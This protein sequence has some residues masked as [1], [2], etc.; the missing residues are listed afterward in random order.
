[1]YKEIR[2]HW[3]W[4]GLLYLC[5]Q[6]SDGEWLLLTILSMPGTRACWALWW[7]TVLGMLCSLMGIYTPV[8]IFTSHQGQREV[9]FHLDKVYYPSRVYRMVWAAGDARMACHILYWHLPNNKNW[10][11]GDEL[12]LNKSNSDVILQFTM[13]YSNFVQMK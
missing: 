2:D 8:F 9:K 6:A 4:C 13:F 11:L 1:M 7:D 12:F 5:F 3:A 10:F